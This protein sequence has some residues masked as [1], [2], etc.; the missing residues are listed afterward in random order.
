MRRFIGSIIAAFCL[1]LFAGFTSVVL[2]GP[3]PQAQNDKAKVPEVKL[4]VPLDDYLPAAEFIRVNVRHPDTDE[5]IDSVWKF[6]SCAFGERSF[7]EACYRQMIRGVYVEVSPRHP[8]LNL[9]TFAE[10]MPIMF[11]GSS[12]VTEALVEVVTPDG[13]SP[14]DPSGGLLY[15]PE[16]ARRKP[17]GGNRGSCQTVVCT[18]DVCGTGGCKDACSNCLG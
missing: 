13:L 9:A 4:L 16:R 5:V 17:P 14:L 7:R 11:T 10:T 8:N 1:A 2:A 6:N 12:S 18:P 15:T 3:P